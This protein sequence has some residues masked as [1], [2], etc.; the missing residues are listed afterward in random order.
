[1]TFAKILVIE[2]ELT[3][4]QN[5]QELLE[6]SDYSVLIANHGVAGLELAASQTPDLIISDV[7]MPH[8]DG[9]EFVVALRQNPL[10]ENIPVI[11]LTAKS[12]HEDIR[13][14]MNLGAD[15]YL[16]K[17]FTIDELLTAIKIRLQRH[18]QTFKQSAKTQELMAQ[19]QISQNK[20]KNS[21]EFANLTAELLQQLVEDLRN[22]LSNINLAIRML[23]EASTPNACDRYLKIL[24][25][26]CDR[27][28]ELLNQVEQLRQLLTP[29]NAEILQR[30]NILKT[31]LTDRA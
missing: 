6:L 16:T 9:Y 25:S 27:E 22:P 7:M 29:Q 1:M 14:G 2:D 18:K 11:F 8:M 30:F 12:A 31:S 21:E 15:D 10:T 5:L 23:K 24:Q 17:P 4:R 26:E 28:I 13:Q 19:L 20:K 3:V